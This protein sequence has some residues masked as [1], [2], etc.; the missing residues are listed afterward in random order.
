MSLHR[1]SDN[2]RSQKDLIEDIHIA[3]YGDGNGKPGL[4]LKVD[5]LE[6]WMYRVVP[7]GMV[8]I[9]AVAGFVWFVAVT[10]SHK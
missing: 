6:T 1:T 2:K 8:M 7:K 3:L 5:R 9:G 10:F 4:T